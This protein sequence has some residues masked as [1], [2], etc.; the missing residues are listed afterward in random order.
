MGARLYALCRVQQD[1]GY[2]PC[3]SPN[4]NRRRRVARRPRARHGACTEYGGLS[5]YI[6]LHTYMYM[7]RKAQGCA[8]YVCKSQGRAPAPQV[9]FRSSVLDNIT[10]AAARMLAHVVLRAYR[11]FLFSSPSPRRVGYT[12]SGSMACAGSL[13]SYVLHSERTQRS[14]L[15]QRSTEGLWC[16]YRMRECT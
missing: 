7:I 10:P 5:F 8:R 3:S 16:A 14:W 12:G 11:P 15:P 1:T 4:R 6:T 9:Q 13:Q 2:S